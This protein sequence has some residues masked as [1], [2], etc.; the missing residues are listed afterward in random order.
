M[1]DTSPT[2]ATLP[3]GL[4]KRDLPHSTNAPTSTME[5]GG[6]SATALLPIMVV[7]LIAFLIIGF[8]LPVLPLHVHQGLG[9]STFVVGLVTGSQFAASLLS[10]VWSG[11]Y[12]DSRGAKHAVIIGLLTAAV[13]GL[14]YLFSLR[15]VDAPLLSVTVLLLGRALL[16]AAESLII[17]G[18]QSWG[19]ALVGPE[20]AGRVI[21]WV[22]MAMFA[23]LAIGAP[24]GTALYSVGGFAAVALATMLLPLMALSLVAPLSPVALHRGARPALVKVVGAVWMPG[25][26]AALSTIGFGAILAFG[27]LLFAQR[28]W[29][30]IWLAFSAFAVSLV[31][32]RAIFGQMPDRLGGARVALVCVLIEA[33]GLALIWLA[34]GRV[35]AAAGAALTGFGYSLVYP[36]LGVEAVRRA[37]PQSRGLAMGAYTVFLDVALGFGSPALGLIAGWAGLS[38]V[39]L[40]SSFIVMCAA[41][42]AMRLL[43]AA[44]ASRAQEA[45]EHDFRLYARSHE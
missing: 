24:I 14:L 17:T 42:I 45:D 5:G 12:A 16:G 28:G 35:L 41:A 39:F 27:A 6:E 33:A 19:L 15:L 40:A 32:A 9:L 21:A 2:H 25:L 37:P 31:A 23:A 34:P 38:A 11:H 3:S 10:R 22:G 4:A 26:G 44:S 18:G 13:A 29:S 8:A 20:R 7:V 43:V 36:G 30:P 1:L